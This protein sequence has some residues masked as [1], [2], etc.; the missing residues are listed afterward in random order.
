VTRMH[1][2]PHR[3]MVLADGGHAPGSNF[4]MWEPGL[5]IIECV[6]VSSPTFKFPSPGRLTAR[7]VTCPIYCGVSAGTHNNDL[8]A[9][10]IKHMF[11]LFCTRAKEEPTRIGGSP[12][13][14][15][16]VKQGL[17]TDILHTEYTRCYCSGYQFMTILPSP[18][19]AARILGDR[20][21][22]MAPE[23]RCRFEEKLC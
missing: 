18:R 16:G 12:V 21:T 13:G 2:I 1:G 5:D 9:F 22:I 15:S 6:V 20:V 7:H 8:D 23:F 17:H 11:W 14:S 3:V 19:K 10:F 4:L